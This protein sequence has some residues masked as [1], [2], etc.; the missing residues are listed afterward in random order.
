LISFFAHIVPHKWRSPSRTILQSSLFLLTKNFLVQSKKMDFINRWPFDVV[1]LV[2]EHIAGAQILELTTVSPKWNEHLSRSNALKKI[3]ITPSSNRSG[4]IE[5]LLKSQRKYRHLKAVN[6]TKVAR[7]L[8]EIISNPLHEFISIIIF[9]TQFIEKK[10]IEKI[11]LNTC[12]T[13]ER[14]ELQYLLCEKDKDVDNVAVTSYNFPRLKSLRIEYNSEVPPWFNKFFA[15]FPQLVSITLGNASDE[16]F[17]T[18]ILKTVNLKKF[19]LNGRFYDDDFY[20]DLSQKFKGK[21]EEFVFNDILSSSQEDVNLSYFNAFFTSQSE[22]LCRFETDALLESDELENAFKMK[23][24]SELY[25]KGF[26]YNPELMEVYLENMQSRE[27]SAA[28]LKTFSVHY[29]NQ[30]LLE[31]MALNARNLT[32]LKVATFEPV[33]VSNPNYFTKL[34]ALKIFF[35]DGEIRERVQNKPESERTHFEQMIVD[36]ISNLNNSIQP[37]LLTVQHL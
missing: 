7:E 25:I 1:D 6:G 2:F 31:L 9:R 24:L 21:L 20:K 5:C 14:L 22:S 10:Q 3:V 19:S 28:A 11:F 35:L 16:H 17:K 34:E 8:V 13:L 4:G 12:Q 36:A 33:D 32:E 37:L 29:M 23:N 27:I 15:S 26:H 18:L 30:H